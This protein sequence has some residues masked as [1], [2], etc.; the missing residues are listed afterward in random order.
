VILTVALCVLAVV[1]AVLSQGA[2]G[3]RDADRLLADARPA[4]H[5]RRCG[6]HYDLAPPPAPDEWGRP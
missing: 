4:R 6:V 1:L 2:R 5:A 3:G